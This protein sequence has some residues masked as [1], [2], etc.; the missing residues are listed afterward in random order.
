MI[1]HRIATVVGIILIVTMSG[2]SGGNPAA[3]SIT[4]Q[5]N[6]RPIS[7]STGTFLWSYYIIDID[8]ETE[9]VTALLDR[10]L[11]YSLNVVCFLN[12]NPPA[13]AFEF[14]GT[15]PGPGYIDVNLNV[16]I[17]H[18]IPGLEKF[19]GYDVRG[20]LIGNGSG[21]ME[22]DPEITY[23]I[24][25]V[26]QYLLNA[27][28]YTRWFNKGEFYVEGLFGFT[29]GIYGTGDL[30]GAATINGYKYFADGIGPYDDACEALKTND[31]VFSTGSTN[32]RNY[33]IRFPVPSP[34][35]KYDYAVLADWSGGQPDD[36]PS[37]PEEA[38]AAAIE[39]IDTPYY[40]PTAGGGGDLEFLLGI[41][42]WNNEQISS[43]GVESTV[44]TGPFT[45]DMSYVEPWETEGNLAM[46]HFEIPADEVLTT[47]GNELIAC[48]VYDGF[49]YNNPFGVPNNT[50]ASLTSY[51]RFDVPV[52]DEFKP[53]QPPAINLGVIGPELIDP[54]A[55]VGYL[56][57]AIDPDG[58]EM[59]FWWT[60]TDKSTSGE[61][62]SGEG[63][64]P[65]VLL[66]SWGLDIGAVPGDIFEV[67]CSVSDPY[68]PPVMAETL[69]VTIVP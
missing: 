61:V 2:C 37:H 24:M 25:G 27:D 19:N 50:D 33:M 41:T 6:M 36:H 10:E 69:T 45:K 5:Q 22:S 62:Y 12:N 32:T 59:S 55:H 43:V 35:L 9:A 53:N 57:G 28:G 38:V 1:N 46:W 68:N 58:D 66:I 42:N 34:G 21:T 13:L 14:N 56:V 15:T 23:P 7:S 47:V 11:L 64:S 26:D 54:D 60:I 29:H 31:G 63:S 20:V 4:Q 48:V 52:S 3:T 18:P 51:F 44:L 30:A 17:T 16:S 40:S 39:W 49:G 65:G 67:D 8:L